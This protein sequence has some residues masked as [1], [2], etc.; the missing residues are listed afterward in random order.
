MVTARAVDIIAAVRVAITEAARAAVIIVK[1]ADLMDLRLVR[2]TRIATVIIMVRVDI[3]ATVTDKVA[4]T[5]IV[6]DRAALT[7]TEMVREARGA[8]TATE[9]A[10]AD[11]EALDLV[12]A[13][14]AEPL[15]F[16]R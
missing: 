11:R 15:Q 3:I 8:L 7:A 6:T 13:E 9:M 1:A 2:T 5:E 10:R 16:L 12:Q 14:W 4:L